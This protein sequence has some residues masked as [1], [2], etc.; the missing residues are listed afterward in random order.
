M[1]K[2]VTQTRGRFR[3]KTGGPWTVSGSRRRF[4]GL[5]CVIGGC[6]VV[7]G[8]FPLSSFPGRPSSADAEPFF[9]DGSEFVD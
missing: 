1:R 9:S 3:P 2:K 8:A 4:I 6:G 7:R 5:L